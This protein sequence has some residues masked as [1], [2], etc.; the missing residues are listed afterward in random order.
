MSPTESTEPVADVGH[1]TDLD[2]RTDH[3]EQADEEHERGPLDVLEELVRLRAG[4][5]DQ[6][7]CAEQ[8]NEGRFELEDRVPD[9]ARP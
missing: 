9:E 8:R 6:R 4:H 7:T 1:D 2:E 3:D 5:G